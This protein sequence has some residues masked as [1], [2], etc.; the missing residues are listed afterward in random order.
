MAII[1][2]VMRSPAGVAVA[3][4]WLAAMGTLAVLL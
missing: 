1:G 2:P 4:Y 3:G